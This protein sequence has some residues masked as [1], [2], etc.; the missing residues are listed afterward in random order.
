MSAPTLT[1]AGRD[2]YARMAPWAHDENDYALMWW[3]HARAAG[4]DELDSVVL[5]TDDAD[6]WARL[7]RVD[8]P[9]A[10]PAFALPW[11]AMFAGI[12]TAGMSDQD[13]RDAITLPA[14]LLRGTVAS[15]SRVVK[16][17]LTGSQT[18][19]VRERYDPSTPS[20]DKPYHL[21][22]ITRTSETPSSSA[23]LAAAT[24]QKPAGIVL[25]VVT[26]DGVSW[27]EAAAGRAW[28]EVSSGVGWDE[29]VATDV[30]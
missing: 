29:V 2:L 22:L 4:L 30:N 23:T 5:A 8:D 16:A 11:V 1:P 10:C 6:G 19:I 3:C 9:V 18:L 28:D 20:S 24:T 12:D 27:V 26:I 13:I 21:T 17:T 7:F 25:H 14:N 15:I